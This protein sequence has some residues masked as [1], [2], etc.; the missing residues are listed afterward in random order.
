MTYQAERQAIE[1]RFYNNYTATD[2]KYDNVEYTPTPNRPFLEFEIHDGEQLP[3]STADTIL[4]RN[5]GIISMNLH[6]PINTA[7][8][9]G[10]GYADTAAAVFRGQQFSGITCRGASITRI[11]EF[12]QWFIINI[13]IPF[14]RDELF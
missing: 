3:I 7:A 4:Y 10:M 11:G 12:D 8:Q 6:V 2:V 5:V 14:F 13:S 1:S 9:T